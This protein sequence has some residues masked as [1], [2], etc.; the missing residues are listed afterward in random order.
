[1]R[2][3][4]G[5]YPDLS[6]IKKEPDHP[7]F[8]DFGSLPD[9]YSCLYTVFCVPA[10]RDKQGNY[11]DFDPWHLPLAEILIRSLKKRIRDLTG[12]PHKRN[13]AIYAL[14]PLVLKMK[15]K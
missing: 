1:M 5:K 15:R 9:D 14:H 12:L 4:Y 2:F 8:N 13:M 10:Y 6:L 7:L 3:C 11:R